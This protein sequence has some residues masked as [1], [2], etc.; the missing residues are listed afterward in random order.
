MLPVGRIRQ[1][2]KNVFRRQLW[3]IF[4]NFL[5]AHSAR[6]HG[7]NVIHRDAQP[8]D[9]RPATAFEKLRKKRN[10]EG[11]LIKLADALEQLVRPH[12]VTRPM[13]IAAVKNEMTH[14]IAL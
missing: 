7:Q 12:W 8:T 3:E 13:K 2:G 10:D 11:D 6:Q 1:H 9:T 4:L 14:T 5:L